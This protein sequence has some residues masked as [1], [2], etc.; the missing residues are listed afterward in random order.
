[1]DQPY[2][3][4]IGA[5]GHSHACIDAIEQQGRYRIFGLVCADGED[6]SARLGYPV[7]G[8]LRTSS[9]DTFF[10]APMGANVRLTKHAGKIA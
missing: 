2:I 8:V 9:L 4:L 7:V 1:M 6:R 10:S 3:M 5:G